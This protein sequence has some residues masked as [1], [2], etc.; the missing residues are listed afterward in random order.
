V[1]IV[2]N[3]IGQYKL[4]SG[5]DDTKK[6]VY[7]LIKKITIKH[8]PKENAK[9]GYF[10]VQ[11]EYRGFDESITFMTD[12]NALKWYQIGYYR[13]RAITKVDLQDDI[14]LLKYY[15][16]ASGKKIEVPKDF[17]GFEAYGGGKG[18]TIIE[19]RQDELINFD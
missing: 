15:I 10:L 16:K 11:I 9:V 1:A 17:V 4:T 6:L 18:D 3:V 7:S 2:N 19:L 13:S 5:F 12:W 14:D 8:N